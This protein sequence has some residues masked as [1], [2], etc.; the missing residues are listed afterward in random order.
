MSKEIIIEENKALKLNNVLTRTFT[1][2]ENFDECRFNTKIKEFNDYILNN[3]ITSFGP[4]IIKNQI[5]G[6]EKKK[7]QIKLMIQTKNESLRVIAPYGFE[8]EHKTKPCLFSRFN[9]NQQDQGY[10]NLKMQVYA[11]ENNLILDVESYQVTKNKENE[12][13][14]DTFVP[15]IGRV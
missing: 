9:G 14:I 13:E 1:I 7:I 10:A 12:V 5:I 2:D 3:K 4:L 11:Y 15:I 6:N 8:T